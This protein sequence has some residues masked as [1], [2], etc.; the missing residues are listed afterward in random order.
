MK[1]HTPF[2]SENE[3]DEEEFQSSSAIVDPSWE[4]SS[5]GRRF[6]LGNTESYNRPSPLTLRFTN[7]VEEISEATEGNTSPP[8][9]R[10]NS[11][12]S[13]RSQSIRSLMKLI[14]QARDR[15]PSGAA[16]S[17]DSS[18]SFTMSEPGV[19]ELERVYSE[20]TQDTEER[21]LSRIDRRKENSAPE[22]NGH[23]R[24]LELE[25]PE[26]CRV[27]Q[28]SL[29]EGMDNDV[30]NALLEQS[31]VPLTDRVLQELEDLKLISCIR[32]GKTVSVRPSNLVPGDVV[33]LQTGD[34][35][36]A[37]IRIANH[38]AD[39]KINTSA[40]SPRNAKDD[41]IILV[42]SGSFVCIG[43]LRG[44]VCA[45]G[46]ATMSARISK[47]V[48]SPEPQ[49]SRTVRNE[50]YEKYS[51][52]SHDP[53]PILGV[54][55][56]LA[57]ARATGRMENFRIPICMDLPTDYLGDLKSEAI[58]RHQEMFNA[59]RCSANRFA[60]DM[61][62]LICDYANPHY[63]YK[64][65]QICTIPSSMVLFLPLSEIKGFTEYF[66]R[67]Q[68]E[69]T[70]IVLEPDQIDEIKARV[71]PLKQNFIVVPDCPPHIK[72][73]IISQLYYIGVI[74]FGGFDL[75]ETALLDSCTL[76]ICLGRSRICIER[77][78]AVCLGSPLQRLTFSEGFLHWL[79]GKITEDDWE[80]TDTGWERALRH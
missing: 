12:R 44:I 52:L 20:P 27:L 10:S 55:Q 78:N 26:L 51:L 23:L 60:E 75:A 39:L 4:S 31:G 24:G 49:S 54:R 3:F 58:Q 67:V 21:M 59:V 56:S 5:L 30:V 13:N 63:F 22:I 70:W 19:N 32:S 14:T 77:C 8:S 29:D 46:A 37:D 53:T 1:N 79:N 9:T 57:N 71:Q 61:I 41:S 18:S 6:S 45:T 38:S 64:L 65:E 42:Y 11:T 76:S 7:D 28:T 35:A 69:T 50:L 62:V 68:S 80:E 2:S 43:W 33:Y 47:A 73:D 74:Y 16:F 36:P 40:L 48:T 66:Q 72:R 15:R 34:I 17:P 25:I